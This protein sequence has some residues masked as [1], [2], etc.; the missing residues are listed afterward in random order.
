MRTKIIAT[1]GPASE[2]KE[3]IFKLV[4]SGLDIA[5]MNFSH[6]TE[7]EFLSRKKFLGLA[8]KKSGRKIAILQ[9]LQGPRIR[10]GEMPKDGLKLKE[11]DLVVFSTSRSDKSAIFV[12]NPYLHLDIKK[13]E[14]IYLANGDM[15]L[16]TS[17]VKENRI[18]AEVTRG[19]ILYS[20]KAVNV[21]DTKLSVSGLTYKDKKDL[22]FGLKNG[23]DY[24]AISFVQSAKDMETARKIVGTKARIIAKIE[25]ALALKNIDSIIQSSDGIMIAR[26]DLG[27]EIPE[28][29][30]P[31]IQKNLIRHASWHNKASI[32]ATQMLTSMISHDHPTR[33]EVSDIANA[34]WD[35]TDAVM[36]SDETASGKYPVLA[37]KTM[38]KIVKQVESFENQPNYL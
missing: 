20:R 21:P 18:Y 16:M 32:T 36:L 34:I 5:R 6:C 19:G 23:V 26:G 12:D 4:E 31:F 14:P 35:G 24:V 22:Q 9:D 33:A 10:V 25:T 8:A 27:I 30:L 37:L 2:D 1:L 29:K 15:E 13:G 7:E 38:V 3:T 28:E 17:R 11:G